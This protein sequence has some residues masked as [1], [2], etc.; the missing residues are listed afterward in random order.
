MIKT[1]LFLLFLEAANCVI[2]DPL[3]IRQFHLAVNL[4]LISETSA[5]ASVGDLNGDGVLIGEK[6]LAPGAIA[7]GDMN[8]DGMLD[9][10]I[11]YALAPSAVFFNNRK[12]TDFHQVRFGDGKGGVYG[13]ALD[14]LNNDQYPDIVVARSE[15]PNTVYFSS[16]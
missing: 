7:I 15:A 2:S 6:T 4:E 8:R 16:K 14:D 11:G 1:L 10:V 13:I 3:E 5:N 12:G 9:I